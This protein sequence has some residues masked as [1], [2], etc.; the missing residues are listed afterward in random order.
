MFCCGY[1]Q[2]KSLKTQTRLNM[3]WSEKEW[4][5][6][7]SD[8]ACV[9]HTC[10]CKCRYQ[11]RDGMVPKRC[12]TSGGLCCGHVIQGSRSHKTQIATSTANRPFFCSQTRGLSLCLPDPVENWGHPTHLRGDEK[13]LRTTTNPCTVRSGE[14]SRSFYLCPNFMA[15]SRLTLIQSALT[16]PKSWVRKGRSTRS[17]NKIFTTAP[18]CIRHCTCYWGYQEWIKETYL[19]THGAYGVGGPGGGA[20]SET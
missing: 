17:L 13:L 9:L 20:G 11:N 12:L 1:S 2:K 16:L 5:S 6:F 19:G 8:Y 3:G 7:V 18:P 4:V 10:M 15:I 14:R